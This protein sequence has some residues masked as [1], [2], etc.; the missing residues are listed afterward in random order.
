[1]SNGFS[2]IL[3]SDFSHRTRSTR[4]DQSFRVTSVRLLFL[5]FLSTT[6]RSPHS[7]SGKSYAMCS[8]IGAMRSFQVDG[9]EPP[10]PREATRSGN[11]YPRRTKRCSRTGKRQRRGAISIGN[12]N[13]PPADPGR[14]VAW[15]YTPG[16]MLPCERTGAAEPVGRR[17]RCRHRHEA[18]GTDPPPPTCPVPL[19]TAESVVCSAGSPSNFFGYLKRSIRSRPEAAG[20]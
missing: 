12:F 1:M 6:S 20:M 19:P 4:K 13:S 16:T 5:R 3:Q 10:G 7:R 14:T 2:R 11:V 17:R 18:D 15:S 9:N 8:G